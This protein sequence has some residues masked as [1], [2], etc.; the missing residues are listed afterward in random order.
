MVN[1]KEKRSAIQQ[2][3]D[4]DLTAAAEAEELPSAFEVDSALDQ[5]ASSLKV[6]DFLGSGRCRE[7]RRR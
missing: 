6:M 7:T 2:W 3:L 1:T 5:I 4:R